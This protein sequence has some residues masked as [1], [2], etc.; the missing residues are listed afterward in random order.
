MERWKTKSNTEV[1]EER[2]GGGD[3]QQQ[4]FG[5]YIYIA[6]DQ[7]TN[8]RADSCVFQKNGKNSVKFASIDYF[9]L[10]SR[11]CAAAHLTRFAGRGMVGGG[12]RVVVV[13]ERGEG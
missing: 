9:H 12:G 5:I 10:L 6:F 3:N 4:I 7:P 11:A 1:T 8:G 2:G 13:R